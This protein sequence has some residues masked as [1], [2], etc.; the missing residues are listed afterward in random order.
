MKNQQESKATVFFKVLFI[1]AILVTGMFLSTTA[2]AQDKIPE[3][4]VRYL[5]T[6]NGQLQFSLTYEGVQ[7][8]PVALQIRNEE[9]S[10]LYKDTFRKKDFQ[11]HF[12]FTNTESGSFRLFFTLTHLDSRQS[13]TFEVHTTT[14]IIE[15][16][17]IK[18]Q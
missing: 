10:I 9:G 6:V 16:V 5:G 18:R 4:A 15:D 2:G 11:K 1:F 14:R 7:A 17:V 12:G 8:G 3:A 13:Q